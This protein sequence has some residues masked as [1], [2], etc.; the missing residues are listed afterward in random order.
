MPLFLNCFL[1]FINNKGAKSRKYSKRVDDMQKELCNKGKHELC[2]G[3]R[4][5]GHI[6]VT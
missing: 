2:K 5:V 1:N 6:T 3:H 4:L